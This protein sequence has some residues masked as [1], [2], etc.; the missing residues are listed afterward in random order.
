MYAKYLQA[1]T[2]N[3]P[4]TACNWSLAIT[5]LCLGLTISL[6]QGAIL[7]VVSYLV[8]GYA[9]TWVA[10]RKKTMTEETRS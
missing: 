7:M 4:F 10:T 2:D 8:G 3:R 6:I 9:G 5:I 1:A